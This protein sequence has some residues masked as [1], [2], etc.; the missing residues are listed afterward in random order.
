MKR[1]SEDLGYAL[2]SAKPYST[3]LFLCFHGAAWPA[4]MTLPNVPAAL[5]P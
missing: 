5:R 3:A 4:I 2:M 1:C